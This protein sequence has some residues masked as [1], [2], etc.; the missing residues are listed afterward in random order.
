MT[1]IDTTRK[2]VTIYENDESITIFKPFSEE[3][4]N[5][6]FAILEDAYG[7]VEGKLISIDTLKTLSHL[8]PENLEEILSKL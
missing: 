5:K 2:T 4:K 7:E 8:F 1:I 6:V 3:H